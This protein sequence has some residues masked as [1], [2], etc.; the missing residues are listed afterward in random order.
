MNSATHAHTFY[1]KFARIVYKSHTLALVMCLIP[2]LIYWLVFFKVALNV[3]YVA[4]DDIIMLNVIPGFDTATWAERWQRLTILFPEHRQVFS[5]LVI[6]FFYNV[7]GTLNMVWLMI[8]GNLCWTGCVFVLYRAFKRL[9]LSLWYFVPVPW[10]W[11]N[12]QSFENMFWGT[13]SLCNFG[14]FLFSFLAIYYAAFHSGRIFWSLLCSLAAAFTYGNGLFVFVP[15][16]FIYLINYRITGFFVTL[17]VFASTALIYFQDF[18]PITK[19]MD[20]SSPDQLL[21][22]LKGIFGFIGSWASLSA[23]LGNMTTFHT[24]VVVG[25][26]MLAMFL[27]AYRNDI[28]PILRALFTRPAPIKPIDA[29]VLAMA[30]FLLITVLAVVYK[31]IPMDGFEGMFKGRYRMY[32]TLGMVALYMAYLSSLSIRFLV[33]SLF[34]AVLANVVILYAN[35][36][37]AVNNRRMAVVQE[38]NSRYNADLNGLASFEMDRAHFEK[39]RAYYGSEDPLAEGWKPDTNSNQVP[40]KGQFPVD[41]IFEYR[42]NVY[43]YYTE[44][45]IDA[46]KDYTDGGYFI[47]KSDTHVYASAPNQFSLPFKTFVRRMR[48]FSRG[49]CASFHKGTLKPGLYKVYMLKRANGESKLYCTD[50]E[51]KI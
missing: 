28:V 21:D 6:L 23:Y 3:N 45:F 9:G 42:S 20:L 12:I 5:R 15:V 39:I 29:F 18:T 10:I 46:T 2:V 4:Y 8:V 17:F 16:A 1:S 44:N 50:R 43:V 35:F 25:V 31:R 36:S 14:V 11:F 24:A 19:S 51:I 7:F 13:S 34:G 22:G 37:L 38:F 47:L 30:L 27:L 26:A 40:C 41:S 33:I 49:A 48:Y 32:S